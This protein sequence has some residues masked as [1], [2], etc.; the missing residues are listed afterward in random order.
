MAPGMEETQP[1][2]EELTAEDVAKD[3]EYKQIYHQT[4]RGATLALVRCTRWTP[5]F[6][7]DTIPEKT[8]DRETIA[9]TARPYARPRRA[10]PI[11][12]PQR[13]TCTTIAIP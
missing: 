9:R 4:Y 8:H 12:L 1:V 13:S 10:I 3:E 2:F 11:P 6:L 5:L 7:A